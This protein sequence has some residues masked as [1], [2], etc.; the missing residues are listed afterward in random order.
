MQLEV[1]MFGIRTFPAEDSQCSLGISSNAVTCNT[2]GTMAS[3]ELFEHIEYLGPEAG[4]FMADLIERVHTSD[5]DQRG[6]RSE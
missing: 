6:R 2:V 5:P 1:A 3:D 4:F